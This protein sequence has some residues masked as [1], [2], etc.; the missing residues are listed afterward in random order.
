MLSAG[1]EKVDVMDA[2]RHLFNFDNTLP[3]GVR[4]RWGQTTKQM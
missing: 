2:T 1:D 4:S 3:A